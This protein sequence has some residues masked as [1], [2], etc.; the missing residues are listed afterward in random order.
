M[1]AMIFLFLVYATFPDKLIATL[2]IQVFGTLVFSILT[3]ATRKAFGTSGGLCALPPL[4]LA[5]ELAQ[6]TLFLGADGTSPWAVRAPARAP[7]LSPP[8]LRALSPLTRATA[9]A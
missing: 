2:I 8:R 6:T 1:V 7:F 4:F 3:P 5:M 9:R